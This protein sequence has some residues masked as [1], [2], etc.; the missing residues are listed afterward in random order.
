MFLLQKLF[1]SNIVIDPIT[2]IFPIKLF[3]FG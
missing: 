1:A 3:G 2:F